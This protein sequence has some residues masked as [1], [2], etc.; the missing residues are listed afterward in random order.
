MTRAGEVEYFNDLVFHGGDGATLEMRLFA[1]HDLL[2]HF[3]TAGFTDV[4]VRGDADEDV[5]VIW[6]EDWSLPLTA[7]R[8]HATAIMG[9]PNAV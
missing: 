3:S 4:R 2:L 8:P 1:E 7:R 6:F 5:G 9:G